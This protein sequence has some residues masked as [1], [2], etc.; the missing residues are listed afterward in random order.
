MP[1]PHLSTSTIR[2]LL[3]RFAADDFNKAQTARRLR[4]SRSS[5]TKYINAFKKSSLT[6]SEIESLP[7]AGLI[8]QLFR[9]SKRPTS[10]PRKLRLL[11]CLPSI[12]TR[13][14]IDGLS[15]LDA[16]REVAHQCG[17]KYSRFAS[18]YSAWRLEHSLGRISR[19]RRPLRGVS[20]TDCVVFNRWQRSHDRR[21]WEV[22][23]ALLGLSFG[24]TVPAICRKIGR[25]RRTVEKWCATYERSGIDSLPVKRAHKLS[26]KIQAAIKEKKERLVKIIHETPNAY[27]INR[28][29]WSLQALSEAYKKT[30]GERASPSSISEYFIA[31]GYK[32]KK[33]KKS[34]MSSDPTYREKLEK[35]T[36]TLSHLFSKEKVFSIDEFGPFSVKMHGGR[37]LVPGKPDTNDSPKAKK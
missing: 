28:A 37:A 35:I 15:I 32:F 22:S 21:K 12:H 27:G 23:V 29:S 7:R 10:S 24:H 18:L 30:Y 2:K 25:A 36:S 1:K 8:D 17:Y 26:E 13:I 31:A 9:S 5:A 20:P 6:L 34:L 3:N 11:A 4:I 33:A 14:E 19:A 16:W